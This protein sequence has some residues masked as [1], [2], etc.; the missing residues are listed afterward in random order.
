MTRRRAIPAHVRK[1]A[2]AAYRDSC[3]LCSDAPTGLHIDHIVPVAL[4]GTNELSNLWPL[5]VPCHRRK[6]TGTTQ[7]ERLAS[8]LYGITKSARVAR[9]WSQPL[10][11]GRIR[12]RGFDKRFRKRMNGDVERREA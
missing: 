7:A 1:A 6:T 10:P 8:D 4:G 12:S 3:A 5:C 9:K 11:E 2:L